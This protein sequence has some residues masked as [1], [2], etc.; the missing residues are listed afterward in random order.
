MI[1]FKLIRQLPGPFQYEFSRLELDGEEGDSIQEAEKA[2]GEWADEQR[3]RLTPHARF[4]LSVD[5]GPP[6]ARSSPPVNRPGPEGQRGPPVTRPVGGT[7]QPPSA[8]TAPCDNNLHYPPSAYRD[9]IDRIME[10]CGLGAGKYDRADLEKN[11]VRVA[12]LYKKKDG[13]PGFTRRDSIEGM[14]V[15]YKEQGWKMVGVTRTWENML[16][17]EKDLD[18]SG[19][20]H[21]RVPLWDRSTQAARFK[22][23]TYNLVFD[24]SQTIATDADDAPGPDMAESSDAKGGGAFDDPEVP[25]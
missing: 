6:P 15:D 10:K 13:T 25:F 19:I 1:R 22:D 14:A 16:K 17:I 4:K 5:Q 11:L 2:I 3:K 23:V 20:L 12:S 8:A 24:T 21:L 7:P 18:S 9:L